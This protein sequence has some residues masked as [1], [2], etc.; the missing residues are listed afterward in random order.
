[1]TAAPRV[2]TLPGGT[3]RLA[4]LR[5][6]AG[7][8][9]PTGRAHPRASRPHRAHLD[10]VRGRGTGPL[11]GGTAPRPGPGQLPCL[12]DAIADREKTGKTGLPRGVGARNEL[13]GVGFDARVPWHA[14]RDPGRVDERGAG[15]REV[16][17]AQEHPIFLR[18]GGHQHRVALALARLERHARV[19]HLTREQQ[20]FEIREGLVDHNGAELRGLVHRVAAVAL[21][22]ARRGL[23]DIEHAVEAGGRT[24]AH[25]PQELDQV[26]DV[27][28]PL[29]EVEQ[30]LPV[31]HAPPRPGPGSRHDRCA[32]RGRRRRRDG[33]R[34]V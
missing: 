32:R 8:G 3:W 33:L 17:H 27:R 19:A 10:H 24:L 14:C 20:R 34:S 21:Q 22:I 12:H 29:V 5:Q 25:A 26:L 15:T 9:R 18:R 28:A 23:L 6:R 13:A 4:G 16:L 30:V 11:P 7:D 31:G 2:L 1:M